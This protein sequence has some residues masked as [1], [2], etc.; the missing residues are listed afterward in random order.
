MLD[1]P[2]SMNSIVQ[3]NLPAAGRPRDPRLDFFR[4][5]GMFII[6][7]AHIPNNTWNNWI[8]ARFGFS[9][10]ADMFVF[11]SGMASAL[12]FGSVFSAR[13]WLLGTARILHRIWQVYWVHIGSCLVLAGVLS[14]VD[15]YL[16]SDYFARFTLDKFLAADRQRI[17]QLMTLQYIP[18]VYFDILPMYIAL[19]A[20]IP[21]AMA[22]AR[23]HP[24]L[25]FVAMFSLW[26]LAH[27]GGVNLRAQPEGGRDWYF[28]PL[29]WQ[30]VFFSGFALARGWWPAPPRDWRLLT[31]AIIFVIAAAALA[32]ET[33]FHWSGGFGYSP[34]LA[35]IYAALDMS[36]DKTNQGILRYLHFIATVYIAWYVAGEFGR[37]LRGPVVETIRRVGTQ[38][39]AVFLTSLIAAPLLGIFI[40]RTSA[41]SWVIIAIANVAGF[42]LL[43]A[44]GRITGW[45]K[46]APW[47]P[48][49]VGAGEN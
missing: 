38:T 40:E 43:I 30:L 9:D 1:R 46:S 42:A 22:L 44:G 27:F 48:K 35:A 4:G 25:V 19:L 3:K 28:N 21:F 11:C 8:P 5:L 39:L 7:I 41:Q 49:A 23:V 14:A 10:A 36:I 6:L 37:N 24:A 45:F 20:M 31:L 34:Q 47:R 12:A 2:T 29:A 32:S 18:E 16:G 26:A 15:S 33:G 13:G 17:M